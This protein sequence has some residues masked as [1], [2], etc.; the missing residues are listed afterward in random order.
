MSL[1]VAMDAAY[2]DMTCEIDE[3]LWPNRR[4]DRRS[5]DFQHCNSIL[6]IAGK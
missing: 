3:N 2:D 1:L 4:S 6:R 5:S